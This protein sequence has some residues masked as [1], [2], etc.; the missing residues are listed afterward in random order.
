MVYANDLNPDSFRWLKHNTQANKV[1]DR[2]ELHNLDGRV[3][4]QSV[5]RD[6]ILKRVLQARYFFSEVN[7]HM[8]N[9]KNNNIF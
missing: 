3:F 5:V 8:H 1:A 6:V 2:M 9:V 7:L 4:I